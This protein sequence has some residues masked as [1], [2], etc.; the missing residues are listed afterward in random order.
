M[1]GQFLPTAAEKKL[2]MVKRKKRKGTKRQ[3]KR[4]GGM[5]DKKSNKE[6]A[7]NL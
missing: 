7:R 5:G 3:F 4:Q 2:E 1:Q 6:E